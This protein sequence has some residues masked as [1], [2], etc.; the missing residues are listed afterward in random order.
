[1]EAKEIIDKALDELAR[2]LEEHKAEN[3]TPDINVR[4]AYDILVD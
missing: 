2:Y 3:E 1:M 4:R